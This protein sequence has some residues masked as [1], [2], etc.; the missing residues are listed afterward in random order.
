MSPEGEI[1][2]IGYNGVREGLRGCQEGSCPRGL[3]SYEEVKEFSSYSDPNSPGY[4]TSMHAEVRAINACIARMGF[5]PPNCTL[6]TTCKPC[7][8]CRK[9]AINTGVHRVIA[10]QEDEI[11]EE[12]LP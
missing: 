1:L 2:G 10:P 6:A 3:L 5:V 8:D 12:I 11:W 7:P 9:Y 4:C